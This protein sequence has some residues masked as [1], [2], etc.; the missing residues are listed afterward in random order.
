MKTIRLILLLL[1]TLASVSVNASKAVRFF[2]DITLNDGRI[3]SATLVGDENLHF[4]RSQSG[5]IILYNSEGNYYYA[6]SK[7]QI[8][9]LNAIADQQQQQVIENTLKKKGTPSLTGADSGTTT[10]GQLSGY[11]LFPSKG[12]KKVL[13]LMVE[14]SDVSFTYQKEDIDR[15]F[16]SDEMTTNV[17]VPYTDKEGIVHHI[18]AK[19]QG[20]VA[21]YFKSCSG[22]QFH[23][24]FDV[25][26]PIKVN[27]TAAYYST[28]PY[29]FVKD[30]C[31]AA[32]DDVDFTQYDSDG[33]GYV[34]LVYLLYAGYGGSWGVQNVIWPQIQDNT[35]SYIC[36]VD[37]MNIHRAAMSNEINFSPDI[38]SQLNIDPQLAGI[39]VM[40]HEFCHTMGI[41]D[42]YATS[43]K[44]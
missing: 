13:V 35:S 7:E 32:A 37:G 43:K 12:E 36:T 27:N 11:R 39:G 22:D 20:S 29:T 10:N 17:R 24:R 34:D 14:F 28:R 1:V 41:T 21:N 31:V 44:S 6:A 3:V 8:D 15:L 23:P 30:A 9:S 26:G 4:Y 40:V 38:Y 19:S 5:E 16:N 33:D 18:V 42:L 2:R 25:C